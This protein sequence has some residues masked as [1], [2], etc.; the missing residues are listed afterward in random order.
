LEA[1]FGFKKVLMHFKNMAKIIKESNSDPKLYSGH[2]EE[3][4]NVIRERFAQLNEIEPVMT[5]M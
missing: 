1:T 3:L 5:F 4:S 2:L